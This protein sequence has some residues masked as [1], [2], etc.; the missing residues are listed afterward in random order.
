LIGGLLH[1]VQ[2]RG[3]WVGTTHPST[4]SVPITVLLYN[5]PLLCGFNVLIKGLNRTL[6]VQDST[7]TIVIIIII[8]IIINNNVLV[9]ISPYSVAFGVISSLLFLFVCFFCLYG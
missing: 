7:S 3:A 6:G 9:I 5:G 4:A 2:Q 1:L 8:I